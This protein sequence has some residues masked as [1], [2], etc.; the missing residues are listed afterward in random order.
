[1]G[2]GTLLAIAIPA[3]ILVAGCSSATSTTTASTSRPTFTPEVPR[4]APPSTSPA[5][6]KT[7]TPKSTKQPKP[8]PKPVTLDSAV[9]EMSAS[10]RKA[11][12]KKV[13]STPTQVIDDLKE[14][15]GK[16]AAGAIAEAYS[17]CSYYGL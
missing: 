16:G 10:E 11:F 9:A 6:S 14:W 7:P 1:M 15:T 5:P 17:V 3:A 13:T 2:V 12:C 8:A 4:S